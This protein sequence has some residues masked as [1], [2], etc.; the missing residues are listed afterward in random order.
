[1]P[2]LSSPL[3]SP[4]LPFTPTASSKMQLW[5]LEVRRSEL[6]TR[7][8]PCI[9]SGRSLFWSACLCR[10][11]VIY[12]TCFFTMMLNRTAASDTIC[13]ARPLLFILIGNFGMLDW[14]WFSGCNCRREQLVC[15]SIVF[16]VGS[17]IH[18]LVSKSLFTVGPLCAILLE[19]SRAGFIKTWFD[20][21]L[22]ERIMWA[23][24]PCWRQSSFVMVLCSV[25][26]IDHP[27]IRLSIDSRLLWI[28]HKICFVRGR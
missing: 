18:L 16:H 13:L 20:L 2:P 8:T 1:L 9:L 11:M 15:G 12:L 7:T 17:Q 10:N 19:A 21:I 4:F 25:P 24:T 28:L 3:A 23:D 5:L 27:S 6:A 26:L 14:C 22:L